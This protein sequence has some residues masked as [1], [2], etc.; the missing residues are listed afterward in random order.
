MKTA[1]IV[2]TKGAYNLAIRMAHNRKFDLY[3]SERLYDDEVRDCMAHKITK[4]FTKFVGKIFLKYNELIFIMACGIVVRSIAP[5]LI[6]KDKDPAVLV[7]DEKGN[8]VISLL[9]GHLGGA[10]KLCYELAEEIGARPVITTATDLNEKPSF[11]LIAKR[12]NLLIE[13]LG[14]LK[15]ISSELLHNK[16]IGLI[17]DLPVEGEQP[18]VVVNSIAVPEMGIVV[19]NRTNV[20]HS[21]SKVLLLRPRNLILGFGCRKGI[22]KDEIEEAVLDFMNK[23]EKTIHSVK[24]IASVSLKQYE[25]GLLEFCEDYNIDSEFFSDDEIKNAKGEFTHSDFVESIVGVGS[26]AEPCSILGGKNALLIVK[27]SLYKGIT[28]ALAEEEGQ[29]FYL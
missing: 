12:N 24:T 14:E 4:D 5:Y 11:D 16:E 1:V 20:R 6:S 29:V 2:L 8:F 10:N 7:M 23:A 28:L 19:S 27:K 21:F 9:S 25:P 22:S 18:G 26:V 13:N 3:V 17:S 15:F